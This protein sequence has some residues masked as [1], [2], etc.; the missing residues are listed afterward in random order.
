MMLYS[1]ETWAVTVQMKSSL[2]TWEQNLLSKIS[3][4]RESKL[5]MNCKL[6]IENQVL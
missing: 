1:C 5:M 3:M 4:A 6:C 2:E